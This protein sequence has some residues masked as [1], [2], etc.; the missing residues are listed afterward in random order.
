MTIFDPYLHQTAVIAGSVTSKFWPINR[1]VMEMAAAGFITLVTSDTTPVA[2]DQGKV[3]LQKSVSDATT[4][5]IRVYSGGSWVLATPDLLLLHLGGL[6]SALALATYAPLVS[7]ALTGTPTAPTAAA[8]T[9]TTQLANTA[10]V[11][12][13][14]ANLVASSPSALDTLNELAA[15][16]GNDANFASTMTTALAAR[17]L[18]AT[19]VSGFGLVSGGGDLSANRVLSVTAS[20]NV[21]AVA[22]T[23]TSTAMTP[24]ST[25]AALAAAAVTF[26]QMQTY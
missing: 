22:G 18:K 17:A 1:F 14:I 2:G 19:T 4:G 10:F 9:N 3:W 6:S 24:A 7:P 21:Q 12:T 16:L 25:A 5:I 20:T 26:T 11:T 8:N 15:A 13:A 23:D